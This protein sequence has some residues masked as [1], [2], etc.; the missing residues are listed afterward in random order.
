M[1]AAYSHGPLSPASAPQPALPSRLLRAIS[2]R[3]HACRIATSQGLVAQNGSGKSTLLKVIAS[4]QVPIPD[5]IDIW[6][7]DKESDPS[8]RTAMESVID[9]VRHPT[10]PRQLRLVDSGCPRPTPF[11]ADS[12]AAAS[13]QQ[14]RDE[15]ERLEKLEEEIMSTTGPEDARLESIY[16]KL[17]RIDPAT[18]EKR[19]G[20][21]PLSTNN[22]C[23]QCVVPCPRVPA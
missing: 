20:E 8:D 23:V 13:L 6:F 15:K 12:A 10:L 14:V 9:T 11:H 3:A 22:G 4:R 7:L 1:L 16:E 19:A 17:E 2:R 21:R 5:F 18:F